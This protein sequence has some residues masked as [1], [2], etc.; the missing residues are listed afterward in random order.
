ML[1]KRLIESG[2]VINGLPILDEE[3][4][5]QEYYQNHVRGGA[6]SF[7]VVANGFD[8]FPEAIRKKLILEIALAPYSQ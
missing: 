7:I 5:I 6:G 2:I 1:R 3:T 8:N 4:D